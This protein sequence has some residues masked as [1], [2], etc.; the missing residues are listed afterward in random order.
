MAPI[1]SDNVASTGDEP[2][3]QRVG[4]GDLRVIRGTGRLRTLLGSCIGLVLHDPK[5]SVGGLAHI[6]LPASHGDSTQPG[7]YADTAI[8]ELLR[9]IERAGGQTRQLVAKL[10]GGADMFN[11]GRANGIGALNLAMTERLL[12][13]A[14]IPVLGRHCGGLQGRRMLYNVHTGSVVVEIVGSQ[15]VEI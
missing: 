11:S 6:V 9:S 3:E 4:I 13:E 5:K 12:Q 1:M 8:P 10:A 2:I 15:P 14:G 7:K